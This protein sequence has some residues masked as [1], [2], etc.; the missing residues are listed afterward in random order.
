M[1]DGDDA[2]ALASATGEL[3]SDPATAAR[4]AAAGRADVLERFAL[5]RYERELQLTL[6]SAVTSSA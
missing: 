1:P 5:D 2:Q 6:R 4:W 3:L